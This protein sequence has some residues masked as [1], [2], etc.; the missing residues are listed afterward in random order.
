MKKV[1]IK[2]GEDLVE[3]LKRIKIHPRE[4]YDDVIRRVLQEWKS[5]KSK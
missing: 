3:E 1:S 5:M 4:T 2:I